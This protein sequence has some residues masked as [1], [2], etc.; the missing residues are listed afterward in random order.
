MKFRIIGILFLSTCVIKVHAQNILFKR[1]CNG[2]NNNQLTWQIT[3]DPCTIIGPLILF[4]KENVAQNYFQI[5]NT[6]PFSNGNYSHINANVPSVKDWHYFFQYSKICGTDTL[7]VFSDTLLI[8][9]IK[10]DST[11][12]DS[13]SVDPINN[14]VLLGWTSNKT[15]DFS[16]YYLYNYDRADP[17]LIENYRDTFYIDISPINPRSKA[18]SY[19]ITSS[20]SCDNR[21]EYG[22][23]QHKTIH[24][25]S[26]IDTCINDVNLT[27]TAYI[28]WNVEEYH[29]FR[30][31][32]GASFEWIN[33]VPGNQLIYSENI[34]QVGATVSYFIRARKMSSQ[35]I[36]SSSNSTLELISGRAINPSNTLIKHVT[37]NSTDKIEIEVIRNP[38]S[39]YQSIEL[40][41]I[42]PDGN[43]SSIYSFPNGVNIF[44]DNIANNTNRYEYYLICK[45]VCGI[46]TD[47][48]AHSNNIVLSLSTDELNFNLNWNEYFT[49]NT[50]VKDYIIYRAS[51][52]NVNETINFMEEANALLDTNYQTSR[53]SKI[54]NCFYIL[55]KDN[56]QVF[57]SKSNTICFIKTGKIYYPNA[58]VPDGINSRFTF[59]GEGIDLVASS[60][61]IYNR[62]GN[63]VYNK[64]DI[65]TGWNGVDNN[66]NELTSGVYFFMAKVKTGN[67]TKE[68]SG[69]ITI[70]R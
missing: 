24:L 36:S 28:G 7:T 11:I 10:P 70:L 22:A 54:V 58:I 31:I 19:D 68:I 66:G 5:S 47:S 27:W 17:R 65:S 50:G 33:T 52:D 4:G 48:S 69:N 45:N 21:K 53:E 20:D 14:V 57:E 34:S 18:L 30:S 43:I 55:A 16:S 13:V 59:V 2:G 56:S 60:I 41:R 15:P 61:Q 67:E 32:N 38:V 46:I 51:N 23:Y 63:E 6:I 64:I 42:N 62:W 35:T 37:N 39:N 9:D 1:V 29:I 49:W 8:D 3:G 12:L 25:R 26:T 44:I 40:K